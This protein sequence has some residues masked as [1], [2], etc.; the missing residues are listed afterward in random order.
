MVYISNEFLVGQQKQI[1]TW[2]RYQK[3][4]GVSFVILYS[5]MRNDL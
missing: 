2:P 5:L 4:A 3:L 1:T